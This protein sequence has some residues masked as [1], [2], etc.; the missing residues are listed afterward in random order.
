MASTFCSDA[1]VELITTGHQMASLLVS[2][3]TPPPPERKALP[4]GQRC[5]SSSLAPYFSQGMIKHSYL[6]YF[7]VIEISKQLRKIFQPLEILLEVALSS[8]K[9]S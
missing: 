1:A 4:D 5:F 3:P 8:K 2:S 7:S 9:V 6:L